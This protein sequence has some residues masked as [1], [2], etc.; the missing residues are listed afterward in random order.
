MQRYRYSLILLKELVITDFKLRYQGSALG[1][2]WSLL[3]P[4]GLFTI[5]YVVFVRFLKIGGDIPNYP[6][7]LLLGIVLWNYFSEVTNGGLGA[8]VSRGDLIRK[9]NFP[10]Y[11]IILAGSVSALINL[12]INLLVVGAFM[13]FKNIDIHAYILLAPLIVLELFVFSIAVAFILSAVFVKL[14]DINYVWEVF[15]QGAF[16]A[17]PVIYPISML[18][19]YA[20]KILMLN[21]LAQS[22]QDMRYILVTPQ[23]ATISSIYGS[24]WARVG[25]IGFVLLVA[26]FAAWFFRKNSPRFAEEV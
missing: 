22:I 15:M 10:K 3:R 7:Y 20:S 5:L 11:V 1:Y 18:P 23:A 2:M 12:F 19:E 16:Y 13:V 8:I 25:V 14:R 21:P 6:I 26:L 17:T 4:L 9:L 24:V